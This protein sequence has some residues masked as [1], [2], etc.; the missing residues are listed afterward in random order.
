[1]QLL[2]LANVLMH[3]GQAGWQSK[4]RLCA[5]V[6]AFKL[7][8]RQVNSTRSVFVHPVTEPPHK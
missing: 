7:V 2:L 6:L 1:M 4:D 8:M 3:V 5:I